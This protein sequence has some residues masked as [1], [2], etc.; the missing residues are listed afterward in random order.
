MHLDAPDR[1][2][3]D[4]SPIA[5]TLARLGA[6]LVDTI[7]PPRCLC[8]SEATDAAHGLC[9]GCW[10]ETDFIAGSACRQ[11]GLPLLGEAG[12]EDVCDGCRRHPPAWD[13]GAAALLYRGS[14][15]RM[16]L[17]LKHGD[18]LDMTRALAGW[19]A[20]RGAAL[21]A[22]TDMIVP[23]PLHWRRLLRRR[24]NQSAELA[25]HLSRL[26]GKPA[27]VDL[28]LR[29]RSTGSQEGRNRTERLANQA[30]AFTI[31]SRYRRTLP[32]KRVLVID[33]VLT[34]G[35]TLSSCS[36]TL[37]A[38]GAIGIDVLVLARVA[39]DDSLHI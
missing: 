21:L 37:R 7:Y 36:E 12:P 38:G 20:A 16:V 8:C 10:R 34:T 1:R 28:L 33:D 39:F 23:V 9:S 14:G 6:T 11:C 27:V 24:Y 18:R 13:R 29:P 25:K 5:A 2:G 22:E 17:A 4:R 31:N 19:M 15:R 30:A 32:G 3:D 35:A 26:S